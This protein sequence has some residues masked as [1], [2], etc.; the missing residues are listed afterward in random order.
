MAIPCKL[1]SWN[2]EGSRCQRLGGLSG[3]ARAL[4][5]ARPDVLLPYTMPANIACGLVWR[6]TG[7][8]AC[9][10]NQRDAGLQRFGRKLERAAV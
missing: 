9:L 1:V 8:R 10:W 3:L 2:W 4:R 7:A 6:L 5:A